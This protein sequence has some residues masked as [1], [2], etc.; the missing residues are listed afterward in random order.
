MNITT[1]FIEEMVSL[2]KSYCDDADEAA[3]TFRGGSFAEYSMIS[4]H[5]LRIFLDETYEMT[6]DQLEVMS[7]ILEIVGLKPDDLLHPSTLNKWFD[8]IVMQVWRV[9]LRHSAQLHS[10][11]A[12]VA[13]D[14]TY[15]ERSA[16][17]KHYCDR[18]NYCVQTIEATKLV[19]TATQ[20]ILDVHC[21]TTR[22]G[23]DAEV[24]AQL[25]PGTR[26]SCRRLLPTRATTASGYARH[27]GGEGYVPSSN[28][29]SSHHTA[30]HITPELTT[31]STDN[32][33]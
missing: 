8:R 6:I 5:G 28:I 2:A 11:S 33:P 16:A 32:E 19:D 4:L 17:S 23:N 7:P 15:Y 21:T 12:H 18:T 29:V 1:R 22:E 25:A 24:C 27:S 3:A 9:L 26:A 14:A 30:M 20:A 13:V 10:P 31:I